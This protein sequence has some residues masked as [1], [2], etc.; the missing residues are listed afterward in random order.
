M[1]FLVENWNRPEKSIWGS[2][3]NDIYLATISSVYSA[4]LDVKNTFPK[5][6]LQQRLQLS[7]TIV[8]I[9]Y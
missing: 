6:E 3:E 4:L 5:P 9:I 2:A 1:H 7:A 8:L